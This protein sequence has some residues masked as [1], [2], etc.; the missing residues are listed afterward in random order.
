MKQFDGTRK[1][2]YYN[3]KNFY[4]YPALIVSAI[5][6]V[7]AFAYFALKISSVSEPPSFMNIESDK[8]TEEVKV[9]KNQYGIPHIIARNE[10]DLFFVE[11]FCHAQDRMWQMDLW[12]RSARGTLTQIYGKQA[13][14]AD[15][16]LRTI[17]L[18]KIADKIWRAMD[19]KA[20]AA[21]TS[22]ADG[23]NHFL[24]KNYKLPFEFG[25]LGYVP[26]KWKP[27]DCILIERLF[28]FEVSTGF[29]G[30][31]A[32]CD[33]ADRTGV[34]KALDLVAEYPLRAPHVMDDTSFVLKL[35]T[36]KDS[37][38][39][40]LLDSA[41]AQGPSNT[42]ELREG[43]EFIRELLGIRGSSI[44]S[45][46]WAIKKNKTANQSGAVLAGDSHF[47]CDMPAR[48]YELHLT[49]PDFNVV[50]Q[51]MPGIP[52]VFTGRNE[53]IAWAATNAMVDDFDFFIEKVSQRDTNY[54]Y[55]N[56]T[57]SAKFKWVSD[58]AEVKNER[59]KKH[60][61][62]TRYTKRSPVLSDF[63]PVSYSWEKSATE[64]IKT[65]ESQFF[66]KYCLTYSWTGN[67]ATDEL[68]A[69][70]RVMKA[71]SWQQ[72]TAALGTWGAPAMNFTF[73]DKKGNIGVI[74]AGIFPT[75]GP[76]CLPNVPNPS[77]MD[78]FL[79]T[80]TQKLSDTYFVYN[81][82]KYYVISANNK[83]SRLRDP[84]ISA[85]WE[86][87]SRAER[88]DSLLSRFEHYSARDAQQMQ[89]DFL[90]PYSQDLLSYLIPIIEKYKGLY[91]ETESEAFTTLKFWD[92]IMSVDQSAPSVFS[93]FFERMLYHTFADELGDELFSRYVSM[94][95]LP[96][97]KLLEIVQSGHSDWF[98][99]VGTATTESLDDIV[100]SSWREA[101]K[102]LKEMYG[103]DDCDS[104]K[105][106]TI[107][108]IRLRHSITGFDFL[109]PAVDIGPFPIGGNNTT[110][111]NTEY[112]IGK[113]FEV[114]VGASERFVA[115]M[116]DSIVHVSLPG[117]ASGEPLSAN[118]SD[119]VQLW[120]NGG[121]ITIPVAEKPNDKFRLAI[122]AKPKKK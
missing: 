34:K 55:L 32:I 47:S 43:G 19:S 72:F 58:T 52:F 38:D 106:G 14:A 20:K 121:Y 83:L 101:I 27:Q 40:M 120:L 35:L 80:G 57:D 15:K 89:I 49:V 71:R 108:T 5:V 102:N 75:R 3:A 46:S 78:G 28:A 105:W 103:S 26:E 94:S 70:L 42:A 8:L 61:Y 37:L 29:W 122:T 22:Y 16:L 79:W 84:Y 93:V 64:K 45:S 4:S 9:Y 24:D 7:V 73:A 100:Y 63:A 65:T 13:L 23:I 44:G 66:N 104:W 11:G 113:S 41:A 50:G 81:P 51:T 2:I 117:G 90:S 68:S 107:H 17:D 96:T 115:D 118:Y 86:P 25:A 111:N 56:T 69:L 85:Y 74:S 48:W 77:W 97:R 60:I 114:A 54:Y 39:L 6:V 1:T 95:S 30:D 88:I 31:M 112:K 119:Q 36:Q 109:R 12:R 33:V 67:E 91:D 87:H 62:Y 76:N 98:D 18:P 10:S 116:D 59:D 92:N 53:S 82:K 99:N 21:L 110:I